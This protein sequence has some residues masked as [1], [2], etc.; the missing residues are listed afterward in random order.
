MSLIKNSNKIC[1]ICYGNETFTL[2]CADKF[3]NTRICNECFETYLNHCLSEKSLVKCLNIHC[4]SYII[5]DSFKKGNTYHELYKKVL[6]TAFITSQGPEVKDKMNISKLVGDLRKHRKQFIKTFPK[7]IELVIDIALSKKLNNIGKQNKLYVKNLV[8]GSNRMCMNSHCNGKMNQEN[9]YFECMKCS[10]KFCKEC[11]K[12]LTESHVC[13]KED[14]DSLKL[15]SSIPKCPKCNIAIE[16]S[17][18]CNGM[19]CASCQTVFDYATGQVST[20]GS[21]NA[22][23]GPQRTKFKFD[24][25]QTYPEE[26]GRRLFIIE[27]NEPKEPSILALNNVIQKLLTQQELFLSNKELTGEVITQSEENIEVENDVLKAFEKYLKSKLSYVNFI[28]ITIQI[29]ELHQT[30]KLAI[31]ELDDIITKNGW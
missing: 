26:I 2:K 8:T 30:E 18:G 22:I 7:A 13:K 27:S 24:F 11:E 6:L 20:H 10:T 15:I 4:K 9:N 29:S 12:N 3:C 19:T 16:R 28:N 25:K 5:S 14:I 23:V 21:T 31:F 1:I 17:E